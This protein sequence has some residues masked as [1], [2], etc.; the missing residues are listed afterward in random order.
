[1][2]CLKIY[3][4][5]N[6]YKCNCLYLYIPDLTIYKP[7]NM[8]K[9]YPVIT[10]IILVIMVSRA[11]AQYGNGSGNGSGN[12][13]GNSGGF[14]Q[15]IKSS[16]A[17]ATK[18]FE[19]YAEPLFKGFG[20]GLN[21]G[22]N[23]TAKT[24]KLLH[25]DLRI[26]A[27]V[28]MVPTS[29]QSFDITQIGL[30][31]HLQVDPSSQTNM[32]P[33]FG[34]SKSATTPLMDIKDNNGST[35]GTFNMPNGVIQYIP[36]PDIQLT[37]GLV[38]NTDLTIRTMPTINIGSNSGSIGM[39]G[40]GIKHDII[41]D[42]AEKGKTMPFDLAIAVNY[43]KIS[44][45][46]TL[47]VQPDNGT[48][49]ASG[50]QTDFSNQRISGSFSGTFVQAIISKKLLFFTPFLSLGYQSANTTFGVLGNYPVTSS[51]GT[52]TT[53][54]DP[55]HINETSISGFRADIGFQLNLLLLRIFASYSPGPYQSAN[56]GIGLGF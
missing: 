38:K 34:G 15:L 4:K 44:Y 55:V 24:K 18:L 31:N 28:A 7:K 8:K 26:S 47:S 5:N 12:S 43:N 6:I 23:N 40:F 16:P 46:K 33:T 20:I 48:A 32:A 53:V 37:V 17:D 49:P 25:F 56:A 13:G 19:N 21:S 45:D 50:S 10:A 2:G 11:N 51:S 36:A 42:F 22:W 1:L 41:Q 14:D 39:I 35:I 30:S 27:N 52:Y 29:A 9:I 54:T 3:F